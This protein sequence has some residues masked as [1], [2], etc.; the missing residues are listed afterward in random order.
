MAISVSCE[1]CAKYLK[2]HL[3]NVMEM[4]LPFFN[5]PHPRVRWAAC[6]AI[7]QMAADF[8]SD[9]TSNYHQAVLPLLIKV[10][11]IYFHVVDIF[12][13]RFEMHFVP[14]S[15]IASLS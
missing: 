12:R 2:N 3:D 5:D 4:V 1:G 9:L 14:Y 7:A 8:G 15:E 13:S 11:L 6:N 10:P